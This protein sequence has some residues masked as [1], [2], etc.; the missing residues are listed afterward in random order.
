MFRKASYYIEN[1]NSAQLISK[2]FYEVSCVY[3]YIISYVL[4]LKF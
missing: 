1:Y 4:K 3:N 2:E